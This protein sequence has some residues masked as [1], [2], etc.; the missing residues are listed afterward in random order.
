VGALAEL[1]QQALVTQ[2]VEPGVDAEIELPT[3]VRV[4]RERPDERE[5]RGECVRSRVGAEPAQAI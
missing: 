2:G 4:Q 5:R 3:R 1:V